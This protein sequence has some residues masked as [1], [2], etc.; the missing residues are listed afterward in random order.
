MII[1]FSSFYPIPCK[2]NDYLCKTMADE[3]SWG[4]PG[5]QNIRGNCHQARMIEKQMNH[6]IIRYYE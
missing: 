1:H 2:K 3:P 4:A 5:C 6:L